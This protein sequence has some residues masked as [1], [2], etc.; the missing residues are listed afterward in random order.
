MVSQLT[1]DEDTIRVLEEMGWYG[2]EVRELALAFFIQTSRIEYSLLK[3]GF[4]RKRSRPW[5]C[6]ESFARKFIRE[7]PEEAKEIAKKHAEFLNGPPGSLVEEDDELKWSLHARFEDGLRRRLDSGI[8]EVDFVDMC[9]LFEQV[10]NNLFHGNKS[11]DPAAEVV[12]RLKQ[13]LAILKD[14][15]RIMS[16]FP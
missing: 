2:S 16:R 15:R 1:I 6:W 14:L 13:T 7:F 8:D 10:R 3:K 12:P 5:A 11:I 4:R 9:F